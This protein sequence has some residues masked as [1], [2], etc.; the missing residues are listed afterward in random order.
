M[1]GIDLS[2]AAKLRDV[3]FRCGG[4]RAQWISET[5]HTVEPKNLQRLSL[6][7]PR[8]SAI[9]D[10]TWET[11]HQE[12]LDLDSLFVQSSVSHALRLKVI[13][14]PG[15]G[16]LDVRDRMAVFLPELTRRGIADWV[17]WVE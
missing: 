15:K 3:V 6:E 2:Q 9:E 8:R 17:Q 11:V 4:L 7:L 13:H 10:T 14:A 16:E 1:I 12:W 5:L